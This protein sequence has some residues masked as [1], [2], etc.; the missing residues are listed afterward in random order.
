MTE[1]MTDREM[2]TYRNH[3]DTRAMESRAAGLTSDQWDQVMAGFAAKVEE[4]ERK[5]E[6]A[7]R[8]RPSYAPAG[9]LTKAE[10]NAASWL[11]A[12]REQYRFW[13]TVRARA[14][15]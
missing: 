7:T 12:Q 4:A 14:G 8:Y 15:K 9:V 11:K 13:L 6:E 10:G 3:V 1:Q 5:V 2:Q